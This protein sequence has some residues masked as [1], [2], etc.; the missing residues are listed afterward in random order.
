VAFTA[1]FLLL[2]WL[3]FGLAGL[4][5]GQL[6]GWLGWWNVIFAA[7]ALIA[8]GSLA[9]RLNALA[10]PPSEDGDGAELI[11]NAV[12]AM[13][14]V[15]LA[16]FGAGI[17]LWIEGKGAA[18]G[19][20]GDGFGIINALF[21]GAALCGTV[22]AVILQRKDFKLTLKEYTDSRLAQE[23]AAEAQERNV[24]QQTRLAEIHGFT[25]LISVEGEMQSR[26]HAQIISARKLKDLAL[27]FGSLRDV[28]VAKGLLA[29]LL[30]N[31]EKHFNPSQLRFLQLQFDRS[32][33]LVQS[34]A[35]AASSPL[36]HITKRGA[37]SG[38]EELKSKLSQFLEKL[39]ATEKTYRGRI[40]FYKRKLRS[41]LALNEDESQDAGESG[42]LTGN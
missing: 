8:V 33:S 22:Y 17:I 4:I 1:C 14:V 35:Q 37:D 39:Y 26:I 34:A 3:G 25:A 23:K 21:S 19:T 18:L 31:S 11:G 41:V 27:S 28:G 42:V 20:L 30:S 7:L 2:V 40:L 36:A 5:G 10:K 24:A 32:F 9:F 29:T 16:M 6:S 38:V 13:I 15:W 12:F